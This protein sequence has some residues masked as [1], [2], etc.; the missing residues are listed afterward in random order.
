[1]KNHWRCGVHHP[2]EYSL[3]NSVTAH[4]HLAG[5]KIILVSP[6]DVEFLKQYRW[7][8]AARGYVQTEDCRKVY[9]LSRVLMGLDSP[10][11]GKR[12]KALC[13][14][15]IDGDPI[16]NRREN[17]RVCTLAQ[18]RM[19]IQCR[20][21]SRARDGAYVVHIRVNKRLIY[22]G[23]TWTEE[24]AQRLRRAAEIKYFGMFAGKRGKDW[25]NYATD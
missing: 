25:L 14:D 12:N 20:G 21:Y 6:G 9:L 17:L 7:Y 11:T 19:N 10:Q 4:L 13:I 22:L 24:A 23:R 5:G 2:N 3:Y 1:M 18:N 15:H 8:F 16:N